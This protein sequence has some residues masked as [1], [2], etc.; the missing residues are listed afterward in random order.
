MADILY[1]KVSPSGKL[2]VSYPNKEISEPMCYNNPSPDIQWPFGY[3]LTYTTFAYSNLQVDKEVATNA[4]AVNLSFDL[5]NTGQ[6]AADEVAQVYLSP[7]DDDQHTRPIQLQGFARVSLQPGETKTVR[8]RLY[9]EQFGYYTNDGQR[10]WNIAP[11]QF[12]VKVGASSADIKLSEIVTLSGETV[13][14]PLR[15]F[16]FSESA[17]D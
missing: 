13:I 15:E 2:S 1:G 6:V 10:Q 11:G 14:K 16:Y 17:I 4:E 9:T 3:G 5:K 8:V 12:V 7:T